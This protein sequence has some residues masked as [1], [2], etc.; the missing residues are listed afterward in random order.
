MVHALREAWRVLRP[1][2]LLVDLHPGVR[3]RRLSLVRGGQAQPV[4]AM[5]ETFADQRAA[6]RAITRFRQG[7]PG[8]AKPPAQFLGYT[9]VECSRVMDGLDDLRE[10]LAD[11]MTRDDSLPPHDWLV[12]QVEQVLRQTGK[13]RIVVTGPLDL[14]VLRKGE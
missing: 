6:D 10:W 1:G 12:E 11:F 8:A 9:R 3:H 2:G 5:R 4:A 7:G 13:A 14:R